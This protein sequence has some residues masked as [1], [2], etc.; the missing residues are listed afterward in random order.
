MATSYRALARL[1]PV[2]VP[3]EREG[4]VLDVLADNL[5]E[6][7]EVVTERDES[8][9]LVISVSLLVSAQDASEVQVQVR[10]LVSSAAE[11]AGLTQEA[12]LLDDI[13]VLS[14]S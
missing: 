6:E 7:S 4:Q 9:R 12:A 3:V 11:R 1:A 14:S 8:K 2:D 10:D 13:S 5:P